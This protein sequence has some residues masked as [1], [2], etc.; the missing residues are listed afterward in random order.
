MQVANSSQTTPGLAEL[1][2]ACCFSLPP[3]SRC[4]PVAM[5]SRYPS[6]A[7]TTSCTPAALAYF[8]LTAP[9]RLLPPLRALTVFPP[10]LWSCSFYNQSLGRVHSSP[11]HALLPSSLPAV[12]DTPLGYRRLVL[13][14]G[15]RSSHS[16]HSFFC[17]FV[18]RRW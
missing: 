17:L 10:A 9:L 15:S 3:H 8:S 11:T 16:L 6:A 4:S 5:S 14:C 12:F 13:L 2:F 1:R 7:P 18:C